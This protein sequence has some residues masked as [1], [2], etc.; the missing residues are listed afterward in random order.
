MLSGG[1]SGEVAVV[2]CAA[3]DL[4]SA[5]RENPPSTDSSGSVVSVTGKPQKLERS[6]TVSGRTGRPQPTGIPMLLWAGRGRCVGIWRP[7]SVR[8]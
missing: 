3:E 2:R 6:S 7:N 4:V 1:V 8:G 5:E